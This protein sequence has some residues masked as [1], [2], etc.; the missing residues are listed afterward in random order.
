MTGIGTDAG[1]DDDDRRAD[2]LRAYA[3]L[4][5][6]RPDL[7][8]NPPDSAFTIELDAMAQNTVTAGQRRLLHDAG[9]PAD[10]GDVGVVYQDEYL[11][12]VRDAV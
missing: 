1:T 8:A 6:D 12:V 3:D 7:F 11:S 2:R 5:K 4:R 9:L 10:Y